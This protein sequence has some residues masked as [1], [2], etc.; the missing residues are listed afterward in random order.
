MSARPLP[1]ASR[2]LWFAVLC[3]AVCLPALVLP[4]MDGMA[5]VR[6]ALGVLFNLFPV[7]VCASALCAWICRPQRPEL[8]WILLALALLAYLAII[9]LARSY[10]L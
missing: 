6:E 5:Q 2:P 9:L 7:Y 4:F 8:A 3:V 1:E 10:G